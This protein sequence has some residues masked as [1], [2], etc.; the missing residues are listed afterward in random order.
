MQS[1]RFK[2]KK[3]KQSNNHLKSNCFMLQLLTQFPFRSFIS[4]DQTMFATCNRIDSS[5]WTEW[6]VKTLHSNRIH[7]LT[8]WKNFYLKIASIV[9]DGKLKT[10][11]VHLI[12][13][14]FTIT[15]YY[16]RHEFFNIYSGLF[17]LPTMSENELKFQYNI[18]LA[19][20][21]VLSSVR[22]LCFHTDRNC[23]VSVSYY[24]KWC[25]KLNLFSQIAIRMK[26]R[27]NVI[28]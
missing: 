23:P 10:K 22:W 19:W 18:L 11:A 12:F 14:R 25:I 2:C 27:V 8:E 24:T 3:K 28:C 15:R 17:E 13:Q 9:V 7:R 16:N 26:L 20:N 4:S 21:Q 5:F 6:E 1:L